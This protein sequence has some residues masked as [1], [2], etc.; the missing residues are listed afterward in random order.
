MQGIHELTAGIRTGLFT[1]EKLLQVCTSRILKQR[2]LN[3]FISSLQDDE[4]SK[5]VAAIACAKT[6]DM[7]TEQPL[8]AV[9]VAVKDNFCVRGFPATAASRMLERFEPPYESTVTSRLKNAGAVVVGKTNMDEF[10]MG[11]FSRFSPH[12][13]VLNPWGS[14]DA[15]R[16]AGGSS[17]GSAVA[18]ATGMAACAIGSDTGGSVRMPAAYCGVVGLKP[19]YGM[20]SRW[21]LISYAS[22]LDCPGIFARNVQDASLLLQVLSGPDPNDSTCVGQKFLPAAPSPSH[23]KRFGGEQAQEP[24]TAVL[25]GEVPTPSPSRDFGD[26]SLA[27]VRVG[28][29]DEYRVRELSPTVREAWRAGVDWMKERGARIQPIR[30]P[31]TRAALAAY[32]VVA[33]AEA[34]SNLARYDGLSYGLSVSNKCMPCLIIWTCQHPLLLV[35]VTICPFFLLCTYRD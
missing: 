2:N 12:G 23:R 21:G 33:A 34:A 29:P 35:H 22:S 20:L 9:P 7:S 19:S 10:G 25:G 24:G 1:P 18:V 3:A 17:G 27:G 14:T 28:I 13:A 6:G 15:P 16:V 11:S 4:I 8:E 26:A 5:A 32:Y 31:H 30:L